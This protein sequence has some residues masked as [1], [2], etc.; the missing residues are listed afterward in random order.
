[1]ATLHWYSVPIIMFRYLPLMLKNCW[2]HRQRNESDF[3]RG[4][5][6][7]KVP[8]SKIVHRMAQPVPTGGKSFNATTNTVGIAAAVDRLA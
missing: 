6:V 4:A 3:G 7:L 5:A 1:M 8:P 2:R